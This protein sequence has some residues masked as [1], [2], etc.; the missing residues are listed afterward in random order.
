MRGKNTFKRPHI[1]YAPLI[2][3]NKNSDPKRTVYDT[4]ISLIIVAA[5]FL[6]SLIFG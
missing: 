1:E 5:A 6:L 4:V 3:Q 2:Q